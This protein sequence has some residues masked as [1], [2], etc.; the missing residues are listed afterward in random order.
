MKLH[1]TQFEIAGK[2]NVGKQI[3]VTSWRLSSSY[4]TALKMFS[5]RFFPLPSYSA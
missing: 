2:W 5:C 3:I 1:D 4:L